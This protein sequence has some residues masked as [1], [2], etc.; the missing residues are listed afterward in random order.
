M[1]NFSHTDDYRNTKTENSTRQYEQYK[2]SLHAFFD[3]TAPLPSHLTQNQAASSEAPAIESES[4]VSVV[5]KNRKERLWAG[6]KKEAL[7][8]ICAVRNAISKSEISAAIEV[9]MSAGE[10]LPCEE[11]VLSKALLCDNL[12]IKQQALEKIAQLAAHKALKNPKLLRSRLENTA[13]LAKSRDM[14]DYCLSI[15][16][17]I[18]I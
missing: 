8:P 10:E 15:R 4:K 18:A 7:A 2:K 13:L 6:T 17:A 11:D 3:G 14:H 16:D 5:Q 1:R 12:E 9:M